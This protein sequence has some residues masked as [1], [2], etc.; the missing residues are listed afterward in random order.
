[1]KRLFVK[2]KIHRATVTDADLNYVG[3]I[4]IDPYLMEAAGIEGYEFVHVNNVTNGKH[5]ETYAIPGEPGDIVLNG[6]PAHHF[7]PGDLVVIYTL[8]ELERDEIN[9]FEHTVVF[10]DENNKMTRRVFDRT[11]GRIKSKSPV[12]LP[13][14]TC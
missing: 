9:H 12:D 13:A 1:M 3:S 7:S 14:Y 8:C 5:W 11:F 6:P 2:S 10:V 4:S